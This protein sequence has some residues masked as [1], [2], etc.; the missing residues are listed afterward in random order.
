MFPNPGFQ[1]ESFV[2]GRVAGG[3]AMKPFGDLIAD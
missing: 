2:L 1:D 3:E